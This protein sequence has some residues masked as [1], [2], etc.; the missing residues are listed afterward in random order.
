[1]VKNSPA[2]AE[3]TRNA[4]SIPRSGRF[5]GGGNIDPLQYYFLDNSIDRGARQSKSK[6]LQRVGPDWMTKQACTK[7]HV[8]EEVFNNLII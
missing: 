8:E 2:S 6:G 4:G 3:D 1:M 7:K 5:P